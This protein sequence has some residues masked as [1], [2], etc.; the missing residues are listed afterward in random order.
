MIET[1]IT[2]TAYLIAVGNATDNLTTI[3]SSYQK[4]LKI[5]DMYG[6]KMTPINV[7]FY[8]DM[9]IYK[10]LLEIKDPNVEQSYIL[11]IIQVSFN[12]YQLNFT[13]YT[14]VLCLYF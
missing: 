7:I 1:K 12:Y 4:A 13:S 11:N 2:G 10:V 14:K 3:K 8:D 9:G 6:N 5:I